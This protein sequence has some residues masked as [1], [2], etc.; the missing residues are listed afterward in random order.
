MP[1]EHFGEEFHPKFSFGFQ[2]RAVDSREM[3]ETSV[4]PVTEAT[5]WMRVSKERT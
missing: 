2:E 4:Q 5:E 3:G 1:V